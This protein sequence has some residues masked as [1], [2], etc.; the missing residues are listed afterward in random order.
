MTMREE[1][2]VVKLIIECSTGS[3]PATR[4]LGHAL[5]TQKGGWSMKE[6]RP[7]ES[8]GDH[9]SAPA[10]ATEGQSANRQSTAER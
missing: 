3:M 4:E 1:R 8:Q 10:A 2:P 7:S 9:V 5:L 6:V